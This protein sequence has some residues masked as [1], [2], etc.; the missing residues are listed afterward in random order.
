MNLFID[1][2]TT[3][4]IKYKNGLVPDFRELPSYDGCRIVSICWLLTQHDKVVEQAYF[5]IKPD[6]FQVPE[7]STKIHGITH[8]M[9][10]DEG[11]CIKTVFKRLAEACQQAQT[12]VAHNIAF[13]VNIIL[14]ELHRLKPSH[15]L[16]PVIQNKKHVCTMLKGKEF[17]GVKKYP[18]LAELYKF[19]YDQ[20]L[21]DAH[22]ALADTIHCMNCYVKMFPK[23]KSVFFFK[24][25]QIRLTEEQQTIVYED[26]N[27]DMLVVA[28]AG[29]GKTTT[30]LTR[31]KHLIDQGIPEDRIMLTTFT[32]DAARDM[33]S[34]LSDILG[35]QSN[36]KIGTIDG[37][38]KSFV[39]TSAM[40]HVGEYGYEFLD[41]I[42]REPD[43]V[44]QYE[45][46][47]VD[48][49]QD[50]NDVQ[51]QIIKHFYDQGVKI[52]AVGDDCQNIY[53]FRG[54]N[55]IYMTQFSKYFPS[56]KS[57]YLTQNFRSTPE[58]VAL[59]NASSGCQTSAIPKT[60]VTVTS[61]SKKPIL[62]YFTQPSKQTAFV[63][64]EIQDL[65]SKHNVPPDQI[66]V[67]S[68]INQPLFGIEEELTKHNIPNVCMEGKTDVRTARSNE[69]VSLCT[70]HK[71]KGLEWDVV[72]FINLSDDIIPKLKNE[73]NIQEDRRLFY[74]AITR[75]RK[76]LYMTYTAKP[77]TPYVSRFLTELPKDVYEFVN[78]RPEYMSG[79]SKSDS[80]Y[81][82]TSIEKLIELLDGGDFAALKGQN[83]LPKE[84]FPQR[85]HVLYAASDYGKDILRE[86]L[87][88]DFSNFLRLVALKDADPIRTDYLMHAR[89][90]LSHIVLPP[91]RYDIYTKYKIWQKINCYSSN[92]QSHFDVGP[93]DIGQVSWIVRTILEQAKAFSLPLPSMVS[94]G[95]SGLVPDLFQHT[96]EQC[97]QKQD[98]QSLWTL[99][100]CTRVIQEQRKRLLFKDDASLSAE[101]QELLQNI[102]T[103]SPFKNDT[104]VNVLVTDESY[105]VYGTI[106]VVRGDDTIIMVKTSIKDEVDMS[107]LARLLLQ[108][109][110]I[111]KDIHTVIVFNPLRGWYDTY[112]VSQWTKGDAFLDYCRS[113][114]VDRL[115][116]KH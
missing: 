63:V 111:K 7:E 57:F 91:E 54:S 97:V 74:V 101:H 116:T 67:M 22:N 88:V 52:Y 5:L 83:I 64:S 29:S 10:V 108:K 17:M 26:M 14:S 48:E 39:Q 60:M 70:I 115:T 4:I 79:Q 13:D 28:A 110:L 61:P 105:D 78:G 65:I 1:T 100:K 82:D 114:R 103:F 15:K 53:S 76:L 23:D 62:R 59:A 95:L 42:R 19:L 8:Q 40:K 86:G 112:D 89:Q 24:T 73:K 98:I 75:P 32:W 51:Y 2:E 41:L 36:V 31:I 113:K 66:A 43:V 3:G 21:K 84:L 58:I 81:I 35:Y 109:A 104:R 34:K 69:H 44:K 12:I 96:L 90:V 6:G 107:T 68:P 50:I 80:F 9:A 30:T 16:I 85:R 92:I 11:Y 46:L 87:H 71:S 55:V 25:K 99:S 27:S 106:D 37:I 18:K 72:F 38:A 56:A 47:F 94:I 77:Q 93:K 45:Y 20:E 33:K 49:F 102:S